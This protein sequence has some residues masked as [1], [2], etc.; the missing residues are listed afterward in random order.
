MDETKTT[1]GLNR[2]SFLKI[3]A[4]WAGGAWIVGVPTVKGRPTNIL[5][6]EQARI[7]D[8]LADAIIPPGEYAG[9]KDAG[10]TRFVDQQIG[11]HGYLQNDREMYQVCLMALNKSSIQDFGELFTKL[12]DKSKEQYLK[13]MESGEYNSRQTGSE[14]GGYSPSGFFNTVRNHCMMGFYGSPEHGGNKDYVS[15]RMLGLF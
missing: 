2:R 15:Y 7:M 3:S 9:G 6:E 5:N 10:L 13:K 14:W 8:A 4:I 1:Q 11:R 12:D